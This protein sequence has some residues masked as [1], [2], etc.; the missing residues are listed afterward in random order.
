MKPFDKSCS[1][2]GYFDSNFQ[3][4]VCNS[5]THRTGP[6]CQNC[7]TGYNEIKGVCE[8]VTRCSPTTCGC[9][10][11][12]ST[13]PCNKIGNCTENIVNPN[14]KYPNKP[15]ICLCPPNYKGDYCGL[16]ADGF[17]NYPACTRTCSP[18]CIRGR[19]D[20]VTNTCICPMNYS[21]KDC[22]VSQGSWVITVIKVLLSL[23]FGVVVVVVG[24]LVYT[25]Y[26]RANELS[27]YDPKMEMEL[28]SGK[29][30]GGVDEDSSI[31]LGDDE[32]EGHVEL[33]VNTPF[34]DGDGD[35]DDS[36]EN[37]IG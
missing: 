28:E 35:G 22:S 34:G 2:F 21:G 30:F 15:V 16:C 17:G 3:I 33:P 14:P 11:P 36:D 37:L 23:V 6:Q 18:P 12:K 29:K 10:N 13:D 20:N 31:G 24:V 27:H 5:E 8:K 25:R 32:E 9:Y 19:C 7:E 1:G 26:K 4:C